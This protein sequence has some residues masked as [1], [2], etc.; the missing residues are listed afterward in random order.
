MVRGM[1]ISEAQAPVTGHSPSFTL[2]SYGYT[3]T[4]TNSGLFRVARNTY[5]AGPPARWEDFSIA[6]L[7]EKDGVWRLVDDDMQPL[8][9]ESHLDWREAVKR[10]Y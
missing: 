9:D 2:G 3:V 4:E 6:N 1:D 8:A 7:V 5:V 10:W